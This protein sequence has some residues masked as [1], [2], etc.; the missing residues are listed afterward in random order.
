[1]YSLAA[2]FGSTF[3]GSNVGTEAAGGIAG[4]PSVA[5][6]SDFSVTLALPIALPLEAGALPLEA[7]ALAVLVSLG[8]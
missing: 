7:G 1:M 6:P 8:R 2:I 5:E 4:A 3:P